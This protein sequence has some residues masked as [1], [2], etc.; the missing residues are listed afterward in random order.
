MQLQPEL[1]KTHGYIAETHQIWTEDNYCLRVH[2]VISSND[3][4]SSNN[5]LTD[6][7]TS[8][9]D[10]NGDDLSV[11]LNCNQDVCRSFTGSKLPVLLNHGLLSSSADFVLLGPRRALG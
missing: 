2:R 4:V 1:I 9:I 10:N 8:V 5:I 6:T 3:Q 11:P 7:D